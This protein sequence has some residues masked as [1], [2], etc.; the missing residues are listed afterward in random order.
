LRWEGGTRKTQYSVGYRA[1]VP[2]AGKEK[3][4]HNKTQNKK[5]KKKKKKKTF[6]REEGER[7]NKTFL[8]T[9][10]KQVKE[11]AQHP[12]KGLQG[13]NPSAIR[14]RGGGGDDKWPGWRPFGGK[15]KVVK[16][17]LFRAAK[18]GGGGG[19]ELEARGT[20]FQKKRK[21]TRG[22]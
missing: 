22:G 4:K 18:G 15:K 13:G 1:G 17:L 12:R 20:G 9:L 6:T 16:S 21:K 10:E 8:K 5:K 14:T 3:K 19:A 2:H 11:P 7:R